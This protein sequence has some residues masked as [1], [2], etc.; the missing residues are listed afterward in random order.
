[1][2]DNLSEFNQYIKEFKLIQSKYSAPPYFYS[3]KVIL[4]LREFKT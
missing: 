4:S 3:L 2:I 1:M